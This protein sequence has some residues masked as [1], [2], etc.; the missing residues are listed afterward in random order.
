MTPAEKSAYH[1]KWDRF[2]KRQERLY[3]VKFRKALHEQVRQ[4]AVN[5]HIT[6]TPIYEVL[7]HLYKNVGVKWAHATQVNVK[8]QQV[9]ARQPMGFSQRI[10]DLM[11]D[12]YGLDLLNEAELIT[13]YTREVI[14]KVLSDSALSGA[15]INEIVRAIENE[16]DM[17]QMR[18]RR[19]ARTETVNAANTAGLINS[20][21]SGVPMNKIWLSI[22]DKRT[23]HSHR[24]VDDVTI[25]LD[26]YFNVGGATMQNPGARK[27]QNGL[28]VPG[29]Q[30]I[31]CR[32]TLAYVVI[33]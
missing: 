14:R 15:S 27:Q 30:T 33:E 10:V 13:D 9:K 2:Q 23:R 32:C 31:N 17:G 29:S 19:I 18:A 11:R 5:G 8:R 7:A 21:E 6:S 3:T 24:N 1:Y 28:P 25:G 26:D 12:F 20:K 22:S 4:Q 16:P